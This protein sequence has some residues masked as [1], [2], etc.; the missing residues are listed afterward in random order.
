MGITAFEWMLFFSMFLAILKSR[1][2][3]TIF[4]PPVVEPLI[5]PE[6]IK[7]KSKKTAGVAHCE[8]SALTN[9]VEVIKLTTWKTACLKEVSNPKEVS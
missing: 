9:P 2:I 8:K 3:L 6:N 5:A 7:R 4:K 1:I